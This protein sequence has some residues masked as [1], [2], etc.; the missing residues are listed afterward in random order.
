MKINRQSL[1]SSMFW[2]YGKMQRWMC[3]KEA[4]PD[5]L[6]KENYFQ[7]FKCSWRQ[8]SVSPGNIPKQRISTRKR[9]FIVN[10]EAVLG[11]AADSFYIQNAR[12]ARAKIYLYLIKTNKVSEQSSKFCQLDSKLVKLS[13]GFQNI[14]Q[15]DSKLFVNWIPNQC[16]CHL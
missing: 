8:T 16:K 2:I 9:P 6:C 10:S 3:K 14:C 13:I 1:D 7:W 4:N 5:I 12:L 11:H 15:L